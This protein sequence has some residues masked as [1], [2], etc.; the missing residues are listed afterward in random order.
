MAIFGTD[1]AKIIP[2]LILILGLSSEASGAAAVTAAATAGS[3]GVRGCLLDRVTET[4]SRRFSIE[5]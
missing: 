5:N 3:I 4:S 1:F 2:N